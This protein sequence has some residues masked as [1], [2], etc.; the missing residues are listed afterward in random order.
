[1]FDFD[2]KAIGQRIKEIREDKDIRQ[3]KL[4]KALNLSTSSISKIENGQRQIKTEDLEIIAKALDVGLD[5]IISVDKVS[6]SI[7]VFISLFKTITTSKE[8]P[9]EKDGVI[10]ADNLL[11]K[12]DKQCIVLTAYK[13][14]FDII[15]EI[16]ELNITVSKIDNPSKREKYYL[17]EIKQLKQKYKNTIKLKKESYFLISKEELAEI[18][19]ENV[20]REIKMH[21]LL[22]SFKKEY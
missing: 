1:M 22:N 10:L 4:A 13:P 14:I 5:D 18:I 12:T 6:E 19:E 20:S 21:N 15:R 9:I 3:G 17:A 7:D 11:L 2:K 8:Y 16:A